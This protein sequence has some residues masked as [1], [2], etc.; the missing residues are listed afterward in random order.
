M[1]AV[2]KT[3]SFDFDGC[4]SRRDV[5]EYARKCIVQG[6][7]VIVTTARWCSPLMHLWHQEPSNG[8]LYNVLSVVGIDSQNVIFTNTHTKAQILQEAKVDIHFDD[9]SDQLFWCRQLGVKV[10]DVNEVTWPNEADRL[11]VAP[12]YG[13]KI[14]VV[15]EGR[16]GK[17]TAAE[18]LNKYCGLTFTSSS[19]VA[20]GLFFEKYKDEFGYTTI[21]E[22][23]ADRVNKRT[24]WYNFITEYN[25]PDRTKLT[26][27]ILETSNT[28]VGLRNPDELEAARDL[29]D[30]IIY[31]DASER[32]PGESAESNGITKDMAHIIIDNNGSLN[33]LKNKVKHLAMVLKLSRSAYDIRGAQKFNT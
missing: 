32:L 12:T 16:H 30:L 9:S 20:A 7:K 14:L 23:Y 18:L 3:I 11:L 13:I 22:C 21:E 10:V 33:Q 8:E 4:L 19:W 17:D 2:M 29:F 24:L 26:K 15:G 27:K 5:Q 25:S 6:H 31:V 28:Y 1:F